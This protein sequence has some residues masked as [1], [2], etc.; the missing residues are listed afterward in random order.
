MEF[1][2]VAGALRAPGPDD[3]DTL[4]ALSNAQE[5]EVGHITKAGLEELIGLSFR[6]RMSLAR[7]AFLIALADKAPAV[8]PNYRW[9]AERYESFVYVDRVVV[10][11]AARRKGLA[12]LL[13]LDVFD[14]AERARYEHI[15]CEVNADPPNPVS[16]A[17]H[18][19]L[20]FSEVGRAFLPDRGKEV[21]YLTR[22]V[23]RFP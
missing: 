7:D 6:T 2:N 18:A 17:F 15:C 12:R 1:S 9:F 3:I 21:R 20:G 5:R 19:A 23:R 4:L 14:A 11:E 13:Y 16:D 22:M 10:A 8:A